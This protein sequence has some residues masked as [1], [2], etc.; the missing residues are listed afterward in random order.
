[1]LHYADVRSLMLELKAIGAHNATA[2]RARGLTGKRGWQAML[3]NYETRR[4]SNG[5]PATYELF[6]VSARKP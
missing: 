3:A 4:M 6:Y 5:L 1:M 2:G